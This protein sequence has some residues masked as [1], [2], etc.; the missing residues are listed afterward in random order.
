[1]GWNTVFAAQGKKSRIE[2]D[3]DEKTWSRTAELVRE[4]QAG[5]REAFGRLVE[6]FERTVYAICLSRLGNASEALEMTQEVF[7]HAMKRLGQL[8]EPERFAGWLKQM[9]HRMAINRATRRVP[10]ATIEDEVIEGM[11]GE[12]ED[13]LETMIERERA[14]RLWEVLEESE[15][16]GSTVACGFL[17]SGAEPGGDLGATGAADRHGEAAAA[18][19]AGAV[20][21]CASGEPGGCGGVG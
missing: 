13:P 12:W 17:H 21:G 3:E 20:E 19:G 7:L 11:G 18:Y 5:D 14:A 9:T 8:R 2:L 15:A 16:D 6:Q 1:M 10:L 4:A